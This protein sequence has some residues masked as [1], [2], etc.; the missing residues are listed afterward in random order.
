MPLVDV[1][2]PETPAPL[3]RDDGAAAPVVGR[4][5]LGAGLAG[6]AA[7]LLPGLVGRASAGSPDTT[8]DTT[9]DTVPDQGSTPKEGEDS[10]DGG[11]SGDTEPVTVVPT[12][13]T[14]DETD[15]SAPVSEAA[16][17]TTAAPQRPTAE[18]AGGLGFL[19]QL[20]AA[21]TR[22]YD[23]VLESD[24]LDETARGVFTTIREAHQGYGQAVGAMLGQ[25]AP[26]AS[27]VPTFQEFE[28]D[29]TGRSVAE[30]AERAY[31]AEATALAT[32][33]D[34]IG[35]VE[36]TDGARML[37][38]IATIQARHCAVLA[39]LAGRTG[40]DAIELPDVQPI[41]MTAG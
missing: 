12:G 24:A 31:T 17:T 3:A 35:R 32:H 4:R 23:Q 28:V 5:L 1:D 29:G 2:M 10:G 27:E 15:A 19:Q 9:A 36:A 16:T 22:M 34:M 38:A 8:D 18:D 20:E 11:G 40:L 6:L 13:P 33:L 37:G 14:P 39:H 7:T 25:D 41:A 26:S 30:L 21:I